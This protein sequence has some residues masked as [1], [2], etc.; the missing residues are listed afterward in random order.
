MTSFVI[1]NSFQIIVPSLF[2][3]FS[4]VKNVVMNY[5]VYSFSCTDIISENL[6]IFNREKRAFR[7]SFSVLLICWSLNQKFHNN[8]KT[9]IGNIIY[10]AMKSITQNTAVTLPVKI[11]DSASGNIKVNGIHGKMIRTI[12]TIRKRC[13]VILDYSLCYQ[14][15]PSFIGL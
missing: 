6:L 8:I 14:I 4:Y 3:N 7:L 15:F 9:S 11:S 10:L 13:V 2:E 5:S 12:S 1:K